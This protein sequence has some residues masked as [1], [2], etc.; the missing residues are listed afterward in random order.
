MGGGVRW[1]Y[2]HINKVCVVI[3]HYGNKDTTLPYIIIA[4]IKG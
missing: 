2:I 3:D 4:L 1:I